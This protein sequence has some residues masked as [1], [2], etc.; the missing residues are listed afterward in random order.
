M[1]TITLSCGTTIELT[2]E[3]RETIEQFFDERDIKSA[4]IAVDEKSSS[5]SAMYIYGDNEVPV[6]DSDCVWNIDNIN[7]INVPWQLVE[8]QEYTGDFRKSLTKV[9]LTSGGIV[10]DKGEYTVTCLTAKEVT[11]NCPHCEEEQDGFCGNPRGE[12]FEC[13]DCGKTYTVHSEAD[14]EMY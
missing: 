10:V 8:L 14:I 7:N 5:G 12:T 9:L 2:G 13:D 3:M 4:Y 6:L 1:K 11:L